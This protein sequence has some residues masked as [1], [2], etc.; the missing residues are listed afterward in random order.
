MEVKCSDIPHINLEYHY[1]ADDEQGYYSVLCQVNGKAFYTMKP[2][3]M[4]NGHVD[5]P[6][7]VSMLR[8]LADSLESGE[9][10]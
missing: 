8:A 4:E 6:C 2:V 3:N 5:I 10:V 7:Y 9:G 1:N